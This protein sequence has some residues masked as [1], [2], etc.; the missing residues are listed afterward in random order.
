MRAPRL[1]GKWLVTAH[2]AGHGNYVGEVVITAGAAE[3]EF[4]TRIKLQPVGGGTAIERTGRVLVYA[5]YSWRGRSTGTAPNSAPGE[6]PSELYETMWISPD[7]PVA[8]GRW[9]WGGYDEFGFDVKL[10]RASGTPMLTAVDKPSLMA[11]TQTQRIRILGDSLPAQIAPSDL[12]FG[13]GVTVRRIVSRTAQEVV[14]ELDVAAA[15]ILGRR[16]I[17]L[18]SAILPNAIAIYDKVDYIKVIPE[19]GVSR[20]GGASQ[21]PKGYQQ[22]EVMAFN[23]GIDNK[24]STADDIEIGPVKVT[25]TVEEFP[26]RFDDDDKRFVGTL[27]S[28]GLFTPAPDGPNPERK[29]STNNYGN[30]WVVATAENEKDRYGKP[31]VGKAYLVVVPPLFIIWDREMAP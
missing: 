3:D 6:L 11:G 8:T 18:G 15:A 13:S 5:G 4:T 19:T 27:D 25:W 23:R 10:Q 2:R 30:V 12:A 31:L 16:D 24:V 20:L 1:A 28:N 14:A 21:H 29:Q 7:E 22:F 9:F 17:T 26:E